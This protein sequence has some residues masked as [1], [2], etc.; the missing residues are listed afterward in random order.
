ME[1]VTLLESHKRKEIKKKLRIL[2]DWWGFKIDNSN[3]S[4]QVEKERVE[5]K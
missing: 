5:S 2:C 4:R 1:S 3:S